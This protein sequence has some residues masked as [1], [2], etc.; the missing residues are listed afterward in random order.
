MRTAFRVQRIEPSN[1]WTSEPLTLIFFYRFTNDFRDLSGPKERT[2]WTQKHHPCPNKWTFRTQEHHFCPKESTFWIRKLDSFQKIW[3]FRIPKG[4]FFATELAF[5]CRINKNNN[6]S[7][8]SWDRIQN[9]E[10]RIRNSEFP[11]YS[12]NR[13]LEL[14]CFILNSDYWILNTWSFTEIRYLPFFPVSKSLL[15]CLRRGSAPEVKRSMRRMSRMTSYWP[16]PKTVLK[17]V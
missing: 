3:S 17:S 15:C 16:I 2:F 7:G 14:H 4:Y 1:L 12:E 9:P 5:L 6:K 13:I 8:H 10:F 11:M